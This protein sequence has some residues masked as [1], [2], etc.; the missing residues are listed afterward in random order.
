MIVTFANLGKY[1]RLCNQMFQI[2]STIGIAR[3][4]R[5]DVGFPPWLN[6]DHRDRF[7]S[8]ED[9]DLDKY[10]VNPLPRYDGPVLPDYFVHWGYHDVTL[11][12]S[13]SLS[14][15]MQSTRYFEHCIDEVKWYFRMVD[16]P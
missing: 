6:Y 3:R 8:N 11:K 14:G 7:G 9:I 13:V 10:F 2:A 1:G 15:H 4:N 5:T 12:E 16:E